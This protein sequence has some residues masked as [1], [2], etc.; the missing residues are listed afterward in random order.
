MSRIQENL[1]PSR[2]VVLFEDS[3]QY[4][5]SNHVDS[6]IYSIRSPLYEI[7]NDYSDDITV[8]NIIAD[9]DDVDNISPN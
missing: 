5:N 3:L 8:E 7:V 1:C 9:A 6:P 2:D 4:Q